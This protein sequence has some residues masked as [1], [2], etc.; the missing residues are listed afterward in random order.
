MKGRYH[1][2]DG[3]RGLAVVNMVLFHFSYDLFM[4]FGLDTGWYWK[5]AIRVWQMAICCTFIL[6][7]GLCWHLSGKRVKNGLLLNGCGLVVTAV[8]VLVMPEESVWFGILNFLGCALLLT[9]ALEPLLRKISWQAGGLGSVLMFLLTQKVDQ[10]IIGIGSWVLTRLP[11]SWYTVSWLAPLG[12]PTPD[13]SSSDY[14]PL[15]PWF[16]LYLT[17]YFLGRKVL[18]RKRKALTW[19][20]PVLDWIGRHSLVIYMLHQPVCFAAAMVLG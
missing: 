14:F 15:L 18:E 2:L 12:F 13:F 6:L 8:T 11:E 3:M 10:G 16:F 19:K 5:P 7:S 4:I 1:L 20:G 17:G 9:T